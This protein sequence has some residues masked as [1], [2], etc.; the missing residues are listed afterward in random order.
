VERPANAEKRPG[1]SDDCV[2]QIA[3]AIQKGLVDKDPKVREA[4]AIAICSAP[5]SRPDVIAAITIG[6]NSDDATVTWYVA[7]QAVN[8]LPPIGNVIESLIRK[9]GSDDFNNHR[10]ASDVLCAYATKA[11]P[12]ADLI[13][14]AVLHSKTDRKVKMYVLCDI[15]IPSAAAER[16]AGA[17]AEFTP[18]ELGV[19]AVCLLEYPILL[20]RIEAQRPETFSG[21][22]NEMPRL[23]SF[24]CKHQSA[25][26]ETRSWLAAHDK[27]L[28]AT[29]GSLR[30]ERFI[31][32]ITE[33]EAS[34]TEHERTFLSACKRACGA[35]PGERISIDADHPVE[36]RPKS[37][38]PEI[39]RRRMSSSGDEHGDGTTFVMLTGEVR[40]PDG[41]HPDSIAFFR[42][43]DGMLLGTKKNSP[44]DV[45][46]DAPKGRF[47]CYT[48][49]FA[50]YVLGKGIEQGPYQTGS[51]Q[52]RVEADGYR[53]VTVQFF[54]EM[55][56]VVITLSPSPVRGSNTPK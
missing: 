25:D 39:D 20:K 34:A 35:D 22:Q 27:L 33:A 4:T 32:R 15:G 41:S 14:N 45:L 50:A 52:I 19:A 36:F 21:L 12:Y 13:V 17:A 23:Y 24:L 43:N 40:G 51:A 5:R 31:K 28:P 26:N 49:V 30:E 37:A 2:D 55:P 56:D 54:D 38:W 48:S 8:D 29:M 10:S 16:L 11:T 9:L 53:P 42:L 6:L 1:L 46:Y 47:V 44:V 3:K 7:Q 18:D